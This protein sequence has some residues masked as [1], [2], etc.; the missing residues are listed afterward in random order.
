M[1]N[2]VT[3]LLEKL[4][5]DGRTQAALL[6]RELDLDNLAGSLDTVNQSPTRGS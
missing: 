3:R 6:A 5:V 4:G 2:H 1:K